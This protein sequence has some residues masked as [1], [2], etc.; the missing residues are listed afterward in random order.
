MNTSSSPLVSI[1]IP[2]YNR[3][4]VIREAVDSVLGQTYRNFEL[5]VVDD[6][7]TDNTLDILESYGNDIT[8]IQQENQGVSSARNT[9]VA[10][11]KGEYI[12]FLDSDDVW[13]PKKL[14]VQTAYFVSHPDV[15]ICQTEEIWVR[16][17]V[18]VNPKNRHKKPS[19]MI[20]M[21]SLELCLVSPSAVMMK[22]S[23]LEN[24]GGFDTSL[25]ACEDYDLWLRISLNLPVHLIDEP[26]IIKRGGHTDQL[27]GAPGLDRF[28]IASLKKIL[29]TCELTPAQF[30]AAAEMMKKKCVVY[31]DGCKKRGRKKDY[32][33]YTRL[34]DLFVRKANLP[35]ITY[36]PSLPISDHKDRIIQ[37]IQDHQVVIISGETG[38][39]KTT[40]I[41]KFCLAAGRGISGKIGCTQPRRIAA[42]TVAK[43]I[44][45]ELGEEPGKSVGYK[46]RFQDNIS[47]DAYIKIMTD[48]ILLAETQTDR[49]LN[50]YDTLIVDE[51]HERSLNIDFILGFLKTLIHKR[52]DL[53]LII[54]SATIDTEKFSRA[55]DDAPVIEVSG[56]MFPVDIRYASY[57]REEDQE[58]NYIDLSAKYV[59]KLQQESPRGDILIFMPTE[60]DIRDA[61]ELI[62]GRHDKGVTV[63]P[64]FA[65]LSADE[66]AKIFRKTPGRKIIVATNIAETSIT[67]PGIRYVIDTGLA[68]ISKYSPRSRTTALPVVPV[69]R[70]S[71]DQRMGRCGRVENGTC[72]RLFSEENYEARPL[73]TS[74]EIKRANLAEVILRMLALKLGDID[75]FPFI[76]PPDLKSIHDGFEL[77]KEL[78][79]IEGESEGSAKHRLTPKGHI[80]AKIP[81]DPRL[82]AMLMEAREQGCLNEVTIIASALSIQDPR[83]RPAEKADEADQAQRVFQD[84]ISDF[85]TLLNIWKA[86]EQHAG[87]N[88]RLKKL[89]A[90]HFLSMRRMREWRDIH[91]QIKQIL[92]E[93]G[94]QNKQT[95]PEHTE[96]AP[97]D[98][99]YTAI[100]TSILTGFLSNIAVKKEKNFYK[101]A[102]D[103]DVMLFP[104]S[105]LFNN[106]H[107]WIVA[108]EMVMTS[109]LFARTVSAIDSSWIE[110]I[111]GK[112]C[113][114]TYQNPHYEKKRGEVVCHEQ[115][116]LYGLI[117][118]P[119]RTVSYGPINPD[120]ASDIF[121]MKALVEGEAKKPL[122][123]MAHNHAVIEEIKHIED[124]VRRRD[125]L[126]SPHDQF[127][128]YK[129]RLPGIYDFKSLTRY[130]KK[131]GNDTFL[132]V[133]K[134]YFLRNEPDEA[135]LAMFPD[136]LNLGGHDLECRYDFSPGKEKDGVS[137]KVPSSI[138]SVIPANQLDWLVP[139][140]LKEKITAL[141]KGLPKEYRKKLTP[142]SNVADTI[143]KKMPRQDGPLTAS[144]SAF[145]YNHYHIS[146]PAN[147]WQDANL[148]EHLKMRITITDPNGKP[149]LETRDISDLQKNI[150]Q[151]TAPN[152]LD[153][154]KTI[155][156]RADIQTWDFPDLP[157]TIDLMDKNTESW[158]VFPGLEEKDGI[159]SLRLFQNRDT[160]L[161]CHT[162]GVSALLTHHFSQD[163][164]FLQKNLALPKNMEK[165]A[166]YFG[167]A[168][169]ISHMLKVRIIHD[170][171]HIN[172][173]TKKEY[174]DHI[175]ATASRILP[176]GRDLL[177]AVIPVLETY[178]QTRSEIYTHE[179]RN[180]NREL[181]AFFSGIRHELSNLVPENFI[182]LYEKDRFDHL[183]RY[184]RAI[185]RRIQRA[186]ANFDKDR[187][188][189]RDVREYEQLLSNLLKTLTE[190]DSNEKR[191][192]I[193][194]FFWL[195]Q[196]YKVSVFAQELKTPV[197]VSPKR[198]KKKYQEITRLK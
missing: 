121:I 178:H 27:S 98:A 131:K 17:G 47:K 174:Q 19:G 164:K 62:K 144:M 1:I 59:E 165:P 102:K 23:L 183:V 18:R 34:A 69:S 100:H 44:S 161:A 66:Q 106:S 22:K 158:M 118:I 88:S 107:Q 170:L 155:W 89:C 192:E 152:G 195:I 81:L 35:E 78:G 37:T 120:D 71:A 185:Q 150:P 54:T 53:K 5:I 147:V 86:W 173:R 96:N 156:E 167:G 8:V 151:K 30:Q 77:L 84:P 41:P 171:F 43:R 128:F 75:K 24:M 114:R 36:P 196:E 193:E 194:A 56:R 6:G 85:M 132:N 4:W 187:E 26:L 32:H 179:T 122:P 99:L 39:G 16:K 186:L 154:A 119:E 108:A 188:K 126:V 38:S 103:K 127:L 116:S 166:S 137:V 45:E 115:V 181:A 33:Y 138:A 90:A 168:K 28:R 197:P 80:M 182:S 74:P 48:G 55:F 79:A 159:I 3:A 57:I 143:L 91:W 58:V 13:Q 172:I 63:L 14:E 87:S 83:E 123:F 46:I 163:L 129:D 176:I 133:K 21:P 145:I 191:A 49:F 111:A 177:S 136:T 117:I 169:N 139:G 60:Q 146:I 157:D 25:P 67:I 12:A 148:P 142:V 125:Y 64:L 73:Y 40:Q 180:R 92:K 101:A 190:T 31:A 76:D 105:A 175:A 112:L 135:E 52:K 95:L 160:A 50:E 15:M 72:V 124:R 184:M 198:L 70:S 61:I 7:S 130:I 189:A 141:I 149:V 97:Y 29:E 65:R 113:K 109:R 9:G 93:S 11:A 140:L 110:P 134:E 2:T 20:F 162:K 68:R 82:S 94:I 10:A 42:I 153:A 51:A 104:G